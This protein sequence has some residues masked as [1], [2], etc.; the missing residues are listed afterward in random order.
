MPAGQDQNLSSLLVVGDAGVNGEVIHTNLARVKYNR[1]VRSDLEQRLVRQEDY[2]QS[3]M[4]EKQNISR[5]QTYQHQQ[6]CCNRVPRRVKKSILETSVESKSPLSTIL[7]ALTC[8]NLLTRTRSGT[9]LTGSQTD[10]AHCSSP[11]IQTQFEE[12]VDV[13]GRKRF[14][15]EIL[16]RS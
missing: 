4:Y 5:C 6:Q 7:F 15:N 11:G 8:T 12:I 14:H 1:V 9:I 13:A 3:Y 16:T 10:L 2:Q